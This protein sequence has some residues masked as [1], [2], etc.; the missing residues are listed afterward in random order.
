[1]IKLNLQIKHSDMLTVTM[2]EDNYNH[3]YYNKAYMDVESFLKHFIA[4][5]LTI[6]W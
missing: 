1:M 2:K 6:L 4:L 5:C 3:I